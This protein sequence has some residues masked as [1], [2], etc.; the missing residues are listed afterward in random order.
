MPF[1]LIKQI[2]ASKNERYNLKHTEK[3]GHLKFHKI[4]GSPLLFWQINCVIDFKK[5]L[6]KKYSIVLSTAW[7]VSKY[8]VIS[9]PYFPVF[10]LNTGKYGPEITSY[11]DRFDA[12]RPVWKVSV[13]L[14]IQSECGKIRTRNNSVFGHFS[15]C[16][17]LYNILM[18]YSRWP[19]NFIDHFEH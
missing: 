15:R 3:H 17:S 4:F 18:D 7:K 9:G 12:G 1:S 8:G 5:K 13:S 11:L 14:H 10:G 2:D 6:K 19:D 16:D